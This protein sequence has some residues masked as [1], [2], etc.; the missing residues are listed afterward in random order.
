MCFSERQS[1]INAILLFFC[2]LYKINHWRLGLPL[3]FLGFKDLL[4]GLLYK[5]IKKPKLLNFYSI[6]SW[7]HICFQPLFVNMIGS[8]FD[9]NFYKKENITDSDKKET[10]NENKVNKKLKR[11]IDT[12]V[13]AENEKEE[14]EKKTNN[15][16]KFWFIVYAINFVYAILT[17]FSLKDINKLPNNCVGDP[18]NNF[19][20]P[21]TTSYLGKV[22]V[23]YQFNINNNKFLWTVFY[24]LLFV[25][26]GLFT[27]AYIPYILWFV[28]IKT[29]SLIT[30]MFKIRGGEYAAIW[31]FMSIIFGI[32]LVLFSEQFLKLFRKIDY[33]LKKLFV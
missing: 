26:P 5:N 29:I 17:M 1:Y 3:I 18:R 14:L 28:F 11:E 20:K 31:C 19:C 25:I 2:G 33:N 16:K 6:L 22:H 21:N 4:Q 32:P 30:N 27:K 12:E 9:I 23:G 24:P 15:K 10:N 13:E 7:I 8:Y